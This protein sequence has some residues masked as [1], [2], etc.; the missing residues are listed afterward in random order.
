MRPSLL[1]RSLFHF[2][3]PVYGTFDNRQVFFRGK[4]SAC[5]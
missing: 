2:E 1:L 3:R 5:G 4:A